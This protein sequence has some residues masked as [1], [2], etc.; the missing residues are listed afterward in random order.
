M[1][2]TE[3]FSSATGMPESPAAGFASALISA[4]GAADI[5][6]A[7]R[8]TE[9][10][11]DGSI[12]DSLAAA[13]DFFAPDSGAA[14]ATDAIPDAGRVVSLRGSLLAGAGFV[15]DFSSALGSG[16]PSPDLPVNLLTNFPSSTG[17]IFTDTSSPSGRG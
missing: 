1:L 7:S 5:D 15:S 4:A 8:L 12:A 3:G 2:A 9:D 17:G 10:R 13:T 14:L 16:L 11:E 6:S